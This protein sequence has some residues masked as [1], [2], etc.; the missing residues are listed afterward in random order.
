MIR[1]NK[2]I[3]NITMHIQ[4]NFWLYIISLLFLCT[5]VVLG[6]YAVKYMSEVDK[7]D[8][9]NYFNSFTNILASEELNNKVIF[10]EA[11]KTN[12]PIILVLFILGLTL[13]GMPIILL[14]NLIKGFSIGFTFSFIISTLGK[15]GVAITLVGML[16]QNIIYIP[17]IVI[18][19]VISMR[20]SLDKI[21]NN[22]FNQKPHVAK[23]NKNIVM[24]LVVI[25]MFVLLGTLIES[26][27]TPAILKYFLS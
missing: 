6:V 16:P 15:K 7:L 8:L 21:R 23:E 11:I 27:I 20:I 1:D 5:G 18:A 14:I 26:Y 24:D 2:Y 3:N 25:A 12:I 10:F 9:A 13:V 22:V 17:C 19:S 4:E